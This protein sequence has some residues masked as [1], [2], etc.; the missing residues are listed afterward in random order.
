MT[1][2]KPGTYRTFNATISDFDTGTTNAISSGSRL[3]INIPKGWTDVTILSYNGFSVPT[4]QS[5][6]DTSSQIVGILN[7]DV[8]GSAGTAKTIQFRAKS[9]S[10]IDTQMYVMYILADG[11]VNN[12]FPIGPLAEVLLQVT[13]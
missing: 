12:Q 10:I 1:N 13:Q 6:G 3:I 7:T 5:F 4:Y 2:I 11:D 9:P 8:T